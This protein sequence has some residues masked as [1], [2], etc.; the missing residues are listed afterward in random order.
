[1]VCDTGP[2]VAAA[3][4]RDPDHH[5]CVELLTGMHLAR[6]EI[7]L[8]APVVAEVGYLLN[9]KAGASAESAF[10]RSLAAGDFRVVELTTDDY[11][12]MAALVDTYA[13]LLLGTTDAAVVAL[14]ERLDVDEVATLDRRH[15]TVVRTRRGTA[16]TLLP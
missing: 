4:T 2:L 12:Y 16:F 15:F 14:A 6:R 1:M 3:L 7:V 13:D 9:R 10:L 8:P 11:V 5:A